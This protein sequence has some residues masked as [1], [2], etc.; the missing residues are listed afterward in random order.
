[1]SIL[2]EVI[3]ESEEGIRRMGGATAYYR[4]L[5]MGIDQKIHSGEDRDRRYPGGRV[6]P[7]WNSPFN[8]HLLP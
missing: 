1:M 5:Y 2:D 3:R 7:A 6:P 4:S 8:S